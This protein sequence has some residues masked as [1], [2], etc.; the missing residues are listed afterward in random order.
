MRWTKEDTLDMVEDKIIE[1]LDQDLSATIEKNNIEF[2]IYSEDAYTISEYTLHVHDRQM[3]MNDLFE[4]LYYIIG[5]CDGV[6]YQ[7]QLD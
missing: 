4:I 1:E 6:N 5:Y 2:K 7:Q 3:F